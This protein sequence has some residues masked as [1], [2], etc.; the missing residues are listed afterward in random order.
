MPPGM[1]SHS[2]RLA[3]LRRSPCSVSSSPATTTTHAANT[4]HAGTSFFYDLNSGGYVAY[5]MTQERPQAS[6]L[7]KG[8]QTP[9]MFTPEAARNA[10]N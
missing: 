6:V 2:H 9:A 3:K 8:D 10:G 7:N 4:F 5:N 1:S